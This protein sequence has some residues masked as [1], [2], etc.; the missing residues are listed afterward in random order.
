MGSSHGS[1]TSDPSPLAW[2][3]RVGPVSAM[4]L[5]RGPDG[6]LDSGGPAV[7]ALLL[8]LPTVEEGRRQATA[9]AAMGTALEFPRGEATQEVAELTSLILAGSLPSG[10]RTGESHQTEKIVE[11]KEEQSVPCT[12][13]G[14]AHK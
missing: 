5:L 7:D 6:A 14:G 2:I 9:A 1:G 10:V 3:F 11:V 13:S 8:L 12:R 4:A